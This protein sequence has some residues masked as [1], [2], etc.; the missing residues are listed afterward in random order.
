MLDKDS[1][2][3]LKQLKQQIEDSKEYAEGVAKATQRKFGFLV[4]DDGREIYLSPD[5]MQKVFPGDR[6]KIL[7]LR[8]AGAE[9]DA[10]QK[11][12]KVSGQ[13]EKVLESPIREF[14][15]RYIVK[16]KGHFVEPDLPRISRW[17]FIPPAAR[18]NAQSG[19]FVSC[20]L[21]RHPYPNAKPQA[22]VSSVIGSADKAGI[23]ADYIV[24]KFHLEPTWPENWRD[25]LLV[26]EPLG[27]EDLTETPFITI[28]SPSTLDMDDALH[29]IKTDSGWQ[30]QVAIAD[31]SALIRAD[32]KLDKLVKQRATSIYL[33]GRAIAMLPDELANERCSLVPNEQRPAL[34]CTL[35]ILQ[36]GH[37]ESYTFSEATICS[38]A[39]LHYQQV[40]AGIDAQSAGEEI[41]AYADQLRALSEVANALLAHRRQHHLVI[42]A[43]PEYRLILDQQ[44]KLDRI[45]QQRKTSAHQ[46]VEECMVAANRCAA[47]FMGDRGLFVEHPGF[48]PERFPDVKKLAEEQ[49]G[50][51]DIAFDTPAGYQQLM[52]AIDDDA[53]TFPLR[54]V[55]SRL[56]ERSR[57]STSPKPHHGMGLPRYTTITSPIR[58]YSDLT[59]HRII[60]ARL[61]QQKPPI[62]D[63]RLLDALQERQD[64]ARQARYQMEQWLK[65]QYM[66]P[67]I[68]QSF[69][70]IVTQINSNGFTVLLDEH[71]IE[72]FVETRPM[73]EKFSFDPMRLRLKSKTQCIELNQPVNVTVSAVDCKQR[74]IRYQL[75]EA[76]E[77]P[78][79]DAAAETTETC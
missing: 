63:N 3:Q 13:I 8:Q 66:E 38:R 14:T 10:G 4:T 64:N 17:I 67:L 28:D 71:L 77:V 22:N 56:L 51:K 30:L 53:L 6:I 32:S 42:P 52:K 5:E 61:R 46:L 18:K 2:S 15:G 29:A 20:K 11:G 50:L 7:V 35:Q 54:A 27:R 76:F 73:A 78:A 75:K 58:K 62:C 55:L 34:V 47:D 49:L 31:P 12:G 79:A 45:E 16:G 59:G 68:G 44:L 40:A 1:L 19:D 65:C 60:K 48:R 57:L 26:G 37:I 21:T 39:R 9:K 33:P 23:E 74:N 24:T 25:D 72:G 41:Q 70:G 36:D 43:R 69:S